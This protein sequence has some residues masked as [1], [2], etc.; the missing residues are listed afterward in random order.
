[1]TTASLSRQ[2][3]SQASLVDLST[4]ARFV[5]I[6]AASTAGRWV[7]SATRWS[8]RLPTIVEY[9]PPCI[10]SPFEEPDCQ[11]HQDRRHSHSKL[12]PIN[13][14]ALRVK[15]T[16]T[17][18]TF[19][20]VRIARGVAEPA[21]STTTV[22]LKCRR[23]RPVAIAVISHFHSVTSSQ[24]TAC[25]SGV[26]VVMAKPLLERWAAIR[27]AI[28]TLALSSS[29]SAAAIESSN[30][31]IVKD[32][33]STRWMTVASP[34]AIELG[35]LKTRLPVSRFRR[36]RSTGK[37]PVD[38]DADPKSCP[39][40]S[41][42][43]AAGRDGAGGDGPSSICADPGAEVG[44]GILDGEWPPPYD[45]SGSPRRARNRFFRS[46]RSRGCRFCGLAILLRRCRSCGR[47]GFSPPTGSPLWED[48]ERRSCCG[49]SLVGPNR[50]PI[51]SALP[52][53]EG[54]G[55][56]VPTSTFAGRQLD[57]RPRGGALIVVAL[58][59]LPR[60]R[61]DDE[62]GVELGRG[63]LHVKGLAAFYL[64][65]ENIGIDPTV[66]QSSGPAG[67]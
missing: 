14:A 38:D 59:G 1:M 16:C 3:Q 8:L 62:V 47:K 34:T 26:I 56:D 46:C 13:E 18:M 44:G 9:G 36:I 45:C 41:P 60:G 7:S 32:G 2:L 39:C 67:P 6:G 35:A 40:G 58:G 10:L 12:L 43:V 11:R 31:S 37:V 65:V 64:D 50:Q 51:R 52:G 5:V 23:C 66:D 20:K 29:P 48:L 55:D 25:S 53:S 49:Q 63:Q 17:S 15:V 61:D 27:L 21:R 4:T 28:R 24:L 33:L 22:R 19:S 54:C 57:S 42:D 30:A